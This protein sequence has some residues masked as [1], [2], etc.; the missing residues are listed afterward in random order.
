MAILFSEEKLMK[1][2]ALYFCRGQKEAEKITEKR[3]FVGDNFIFT[4]FIQFATITL[5]Q[6]EE[7]IRMTS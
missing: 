5:K 3:H 2:N 7:K 6:W 4:I 1:N